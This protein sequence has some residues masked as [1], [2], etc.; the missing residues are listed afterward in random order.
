M[1]SFDYT[2]N[3]EMGLHARPVGRM[4]KAVTPHKDVNVTVRFGEK[5]ADAKR[6][7]AIMSLQVKQGDT[8]TVNV[9]GENEQAIADEIKE[10]FISEKL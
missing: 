5:T 10:I 8:I 3:D 1:V 7:F 2:V 9:E 6:M 4:V